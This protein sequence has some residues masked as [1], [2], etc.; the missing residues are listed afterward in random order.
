MTNRSGFILVETLVALTIFGIIALSGLSLFSSFSSI[1]DDPVH[2][3]LYETIDRL[4]HD[5]SFHETEP[6]ITLIEETRYDKGPTWRVYRVTPEGS[7]KEIQVPVF[8]PEGSR[9]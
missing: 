7:D 6:G 2:T 3:D 1:V 4:R 9:P 8:Y 5:R